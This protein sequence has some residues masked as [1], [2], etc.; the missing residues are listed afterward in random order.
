MAFS[1]GFNGDYTSLNTI[2]KTLEAKS[3][4]IPGVTANA[5]LT[6]T[7]NGEVAFFYTDGASNNG[8]GTVG[9]QLT[10]VSSGVNRHDISLTN[11]LTIKDVI[12]N[13]NASTVSGDVIAVKVAN[14]ALRRM[15]SWHAAAATA[16]ETSASAKTYTALSTT[17]L[18]YDVIVDAIQAFKTANKAQ[19]LAPTAVLVSPS[20][21]GKLLKDD[22][23]TR[24][25]PLSNMVLEDGQVRKINGAMII[26]CADLGTYD[27]IVMHANGFAAP[28]NINS[29][30]VTDG[31][32][33]GQFIYA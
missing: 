18:A 7:A 19:G 5:D 6:V 9:A 8:T 17:N 25:A 21:K 15:N 28:I 1:N 13:V 26:E 27:F 29:L 11:A 33:A 4:I 32:A 3:Y 14:E 2:L 16:L 22:R 23:Y 10:Y 24:T 12:P 20:F 31:T 30:V